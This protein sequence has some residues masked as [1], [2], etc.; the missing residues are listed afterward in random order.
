M[1]IEKLK[2]GTINQSNRK[3]KHAI[4]TENR[5]LM[6]EYIIYPL[7]LEL[8]KNYSRAE[9]YHKIRNKVSIEK[10]IQVQKCLGGL[11]SLL[12]KGILTQDKKYYSIHYKLIPYMRKNANLDYEIVLRELRSK[13]KSSDIDHSAS[14]VYFILFLLLFAF[15]RFIIG[16]YIDTEKAKATI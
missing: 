7:V 1:T 4:S 11:V 15:Y 13:N 2:Y 10:N 3:E 9:E 8:D 5:R 16:C 14:I 12:L 6:W